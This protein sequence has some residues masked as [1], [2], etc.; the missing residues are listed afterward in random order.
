MYSFNQT[1][2]LQLSYSRRIN[3]PT[4]RQINPFIDKS[5]LEVFR[6]GNP[7]LNPEYINS[8]ELGYNGNWGKTNAGVTIFYKQISNLINQVTLLDSIGISHIAPQNITSCQNLGFELTYELVPTHWWK[9]NGNGSFYKYL[10]Q[11]DNI[12]NSNSNYSYNARLNNIFTPINKTSIQLV[13][14]YTGPIIAI[15]SKMKPQFSIDIAV[16]RDFFDNKLSLTARATDIFNTLKSS[17]TSWSTNFTADNW[18]KMQTRVFYISVSYNFGTNGS[19]KSKSNGNNEST[20]S[21]EIF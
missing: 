13:S 19:K 16:K 6:S 15:T 2:E 9:F 12:G 7:N 4:A 20:H 8:F 1:N 5:N 10:L 21:T 3:R 14:N 18:R 17:Y 11:S